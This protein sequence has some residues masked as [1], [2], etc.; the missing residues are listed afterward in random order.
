MQPTLTGKTVELRPLLAEHVQNLLDAV[1]DG[2]L[3]N[4]CVYC[5]G[6]SPGAT[7]VPSCRS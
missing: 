5:H 4:R 1:A 2:Q 6:R 3:W 7:R